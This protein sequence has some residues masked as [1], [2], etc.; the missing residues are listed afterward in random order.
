MVE[1]ERPG[2][3]EKGRAGVG[4]EGAAGALPA[5]RG[6]KRRGSDRR[7]RARERPFDCHQQH[8][9]RASTSLSEMLK[10]IV[11]GASGVLGRAVMRVLDAAD[12]IEG[13]SM[14]V[15]PATSP[16]LRAAVDA[17]C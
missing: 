6:S 12:D 5:L 15:Y 14:E 4:T 1:S 16:F 17:W 2:G 8:P 13:S 9:D 10:T 7:G 11:T 3:G